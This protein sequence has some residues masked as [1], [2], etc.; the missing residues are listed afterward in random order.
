MSMPSAPSI[1]L[2]AGN[3]GRLWIL[4]FARAGLTRAAAA[5]LDVIDELVPPVAEAAAGPD[6]AVPRR[7]G[8]E[9][10]TLLRDLID[11][12]PAIGE[13]VLHLHRLVLRQVARRPDR[14]VRD[15]RFVARRVSL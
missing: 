7:A 5:L 12:R 9:Q 6:V 15:L 3:S 8:D 1:T 14:R 11:R 4:S 10:T 13:D 2:P